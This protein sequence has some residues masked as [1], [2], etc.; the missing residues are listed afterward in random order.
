M[1]SYPTGREGALALG[2]N[3]EIIDAAG[4]GL[5]AS[6]C[7]VGNPFS[8]FPIKPGSTI[9]DI[10]CGAGFD[11]YVAAR[12]TG[13]EGRVHG[14]DLTKAMVAKAR[15]NLK[16]T[17]ITNFDVWHVDF[18]DLPFE[19]KSFDVVLS[20]GV[21]NLSP[22]KEILFGEIFRVLR[23]DGRFGFA[24]IVLDKEIPASIAASAES[25]AA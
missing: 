2:Y 22:E 7:G 18:E 4:P 14:I 12:L 6:F 5:L 17:G 23:P 20:N 15:E 24:D 1:F 25:W 8:L 16:R 10:G 21:I 13:P 19:D 9:L 11:L 3:P